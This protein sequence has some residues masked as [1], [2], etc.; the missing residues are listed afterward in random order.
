MTLPLLVR[1]PKTI[2]IVDKKVNF[3]YYFTLLGTI[4]FCIMNAIIN[5]RYLT[6]IGFSPSISY[7]VVLASLN[8]ASNFNISSEVVCNDSAWQ[9]SRFAAVR[10]R[11]LPWCTP[12]SSGRCKEPVLATTKTHSQEV[13]VLVSARTQKSGLGGVT[14]P[15]TSPPSSSF[16]S[17]DFDFV[18]ASQVVKVNITYK[19]ILSSAVPVFGT[20]NRGLK[21]VNTNLNV[22]TIVN[23]RNG[24]K[25]RRFEPRE[26]VVLSAAEI[27]F[28]ASYSLK[29]N[30]LL[31]HLQQDTFRHSLGP[32]SLQDVTGSRTH[33]PA[34]VLASGAEVRSQ[35]ECFNDDLDAKA[36][37]H[38]NVG[39]SLNTPV[40]ILRWQLFATSASIREA[41]SASG[42][43]IVGSAES[44]G[45]RIMAAEAAM[46]LSEHGMG[47]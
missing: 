42:P 19:G 46:V 36:A 21:L 14:L 44:L 12:I 22:I 35:L 32:T 28:L 29:D 38:I 34:W 1:I 17:Y 13:L 16:A 41:A 9:V 6:S 33:F 15:D 24:A 2:T 43:G 30:D 25:F 10:Y 40:C 11:C 39:A 5:R 18:P 20:L 8:D 26:D 7:N 23:D 37:G 4:T 31:L 47:I 27:L 3:L 45:I